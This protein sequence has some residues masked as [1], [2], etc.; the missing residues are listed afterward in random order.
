MFELAAKTKKLLDLFVNAPYGTTFTYGQILQ[1]TGCDLSEQ[2]RQRIYTVR[3]HLERNHQKTVLNLRGLGYK[4]AEANQH[5]DSMMVRKG[6]AS[7]QVALARRTG[8]ATNLSLLDR[9]E[10]KTLSDAQAWMSRAEQI[11]LHHDRR[12][13]RLEARMNRVDPGGESLEIEGTAEEDVT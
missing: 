6:R 7:R 8:A 12:I 13:E 11:L 5:F 2:D 3:D 1:A 4:V 10:V 9:D